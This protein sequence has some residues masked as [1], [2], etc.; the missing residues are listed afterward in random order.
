MQRLLL[1]SKYTL[2][3]LLMIVGLCTTT[4][5][6]SN[7]VSVALGQSQLSH[8][9]SSLPDNLGT[10][11]FSA[12]FAAQNLPFNWLIA[13]RLGSKDTLK[14]TQIFLGI[15]DYHTLSSKKLEL[16]YGGGAQLS[17]Y[18]I[19]RLGQTD[20]SDDGAGLY[21]EAGLSRM[22]TSSWSVGGQLLLS[23]AQFTSGGRL[24]KLNGIEL[25]LFSAFRY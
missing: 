15:R 21:A 4:N 7:H 17:G 25:S 3:G 23:T 16:F 19:D 24:E 22:I 14:T 20:Y 2:I 8:D 12:D 10:L 5:A 6:S 11:S 1:T 9:T 18:S 13:G